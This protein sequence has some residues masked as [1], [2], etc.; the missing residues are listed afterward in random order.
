MFLLLFPR[1][2]ASYFLF[3]YKEWLRLQP[4]R[5]KM[6]S[7][8]KEP[9]LHPPNVSRQKQ[10]ASNSQQEETRENHPWHKFVHIIIYG[11]S[12]R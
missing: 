6:I 3:L 5:F 11:T 8:Q 2:P 7:Y 10:H 12:E 4:K 1:F 9:A